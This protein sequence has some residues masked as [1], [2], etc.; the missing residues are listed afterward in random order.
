MDIVSG[1]SIPGLLVENYERWGSDRVCM[2]KKRYGI[3]EEYTWK[4]CY[5][6][7]KFISLGL[8]DVGL[9][10]GDKVAII[11]DN[12]PEWVWAQWAVQT[13]GGI[14]VGIFVDCTPAE[15][16]FLA[17]YADC[18]FAFAKDQEQVDK[19]LSIKQELSLSGK[20]IYWNPSGLKFY[21]DPML[22]SWEALAERGKIYD[23]A[24]PG[25]FGQMVTRVKADDVANLFY[26]SG[27]TG[28]PK[29]A[30]ITHKSLINSA[31]KYLA[32]SEYT[33]ACNYLS[34][35]PLAWI[36]ESVMASASPLVGNYFVNFIESA[37][38]FHI[39]IRDIAPDIYF[40][41]PR[42]WE[43]YIATARIKV[44]DAG[45]LKR[46]CY[47]LCLPIGYKIADLHLRGRKANFFW[48]IL[49]AFSYIIVFRPLRDKFGMGNAQIPM[50]G[51]ALMG[52]DTMR[53]LGALGIRL[54]QLYGATETGLTVC[55]HPRN[56][57]DWETVG[58]P[59]YQVEVRISDEGEAIVRS[60]CIF[61]GYYKN[62]EASVQTLRNG[63]VHTGD[64][65]H[66]NDAG[67][68]IFLDR[69]AELNSLADGTKYA[70]QYIETK[71]RFSTYI[72]EAFAVCGP[73]HSYIGAIINIDFNN[74]GKWAQDH[75]IP[76]TTFIDLS[77][78][79][80]TSDLIL[81]DIKQLNRTLPKG[82]QIKKYV[83]L[84]KEFDPD[85]GE[86]TRTRKLRRKSVQETYTEVIDA[87]YAN[88]EEC[89][90][91]AVARYRDGRKSVVTAEVKIRVTGD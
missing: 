51:S 8:V 81:K 79:Q 31:K 23:E 45:F 80:E 2:R 58:P 30:T 69:L 71:L 87:I 36:G 34:Y 85:E 12:D 43:D 83:L 39:D 53:F 18:K 70:P 67:H 21:D 90:V 47:N 15:I 19:F 10:K 11:G 89:P 82:C 22:I 63:W 9:E 48:K 74:V 13:A 75:R 7:V 37:E 65:C 56:N 91:E 77:Q 86:L 44:S 62:Q 27:T 14:V 73:D 20:V 49:Y 52:P 26:T 64:A 54:R 41:A 17:E 57:V 61:E 76:Y 5:E 4:D 6:A 55:I 35:A 3:W 38:T 68:I 25:I 24:H 32:V 28:L 72:K 46:L 59:C 40:L 78:K 60:D 1:D 29:A 16:K 50:S 88:K 66:V 84:H 33:H 42:Q